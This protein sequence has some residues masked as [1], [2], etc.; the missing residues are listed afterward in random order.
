MFVIPTSLTGAQLLVGQ[1]ALCVIPAWQR[2]YSGKKSSQVNN[3]KLI[4]LAKD[5]VKIWPIA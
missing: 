2:H 4:T 5:A 1:S 3:W